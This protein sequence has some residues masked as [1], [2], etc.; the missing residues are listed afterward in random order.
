MK[1]AARIHMHVMGRENYSLDAHLFCNNLLKTSTCDLFS[2]NFLM[3]LLCVLSAWKLSIIMCFEH[4]EMEEN[5]HM[6]DVLMNISILKLL[7]CTVL[8]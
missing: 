4:L 6:Y 7:I 5:K 1:A 3:L 2:S 8:G